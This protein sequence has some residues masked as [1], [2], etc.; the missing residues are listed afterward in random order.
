M[1]MFRTATLLLMMVCVAL[2]QYNRWQPEGEQIPGPHGNSA[3]PEWVTEMQGWTRE[4]PS[5]FDAWLA[6]IRA[7]RN[8]RLVRIG[9]HDSEYRRP[10]FQWAQRN[11]ISPQVM[12]EER[13]LF[14]PATSQYTV[15]R[16]LKDL[17]QRYGGIDSVLIWPVYPNLGI[18]DRNLLDF[19]RDLPGGLPALRKMVDDFHRHNV[20]VFFPMMPW[21]VGTRPEGVPLWESVAKLMAEVGADGVNGD[22]FAGVPRAF[23]DASDRTGHP[24][25]FEPENDLSGD[26]QLI[27]NLQ[28]W[29]YWNYSWEPKISKLKWLESRH[30][31]N[32]CN[33]WARDKNDDLQYA[34]FNGVGYVSWENIWGIWNGITP[35]DGEAL[36]R[37]SRIERQF[38]P[39][40]VSRDWLPHIPVLQFGSFASQFPS[41]NQTLWLFVNRNAYDLAGDQIRVPHHDGTRYFDVYHGVELQPK[42]ENG[43]AVL[44]FELESRGYG[45]ILAA[46]E[47]DTNLASFLAEM[48]QMTAHRLRDFSGV[49]KTL[50]Q[51]AVEIPSAK[52]SGKPPDG[53]IRIPAGKFDFRVSG[54]EIEGSND[55]GVDVQYPWENSPRRHHLH[56][57]AVPSLYIDKY[58]VTNAEFKR[59]LDASGYHPPD[60]HNFL[61][62]WNNGA[63][64][65]GWAKKP[66]T[67]VSIE[68]ARAYARWAGKRLPHEWEWQ[69][70]AQGTDGRT[71][72]WG[73]E[74]NP[75]ALPAPTHGRTMF[76][77]DDVDAHPKGASPFG[78]MD[79]TGNVWQ[80]T[81]EY[82]DEHTRAAILRGSG[83][84]HP[85]GSLWYFPTAYK[86]SEHGKLLLIGPGKD[87]S[88]SV[89]FRCVMDAE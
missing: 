49:W 2:G 29:G 26:E 71:Y 18:D 52:S 74:W 38:A 42:V 89:G 9:Y 12:V 72:P 20:K 14:D 1:K 55:E 82:V 64:P 51:H 21:D 37:V 5:D 16:Y 19:Y 8:E 60:P 79:L 77:P 6:D 40:L 83:S 63:Y 7:W 86:L 39:L 50:P 45:A 85:E 69:Y 44:A 67:W 47:S 32:V 36:R 65:E 4:R 48:K 43:S 25:V 27:W 78:V 54:V 22:T 30:M 34:F 3:Q 53:M 41:G 23:R 15:D 62:S 88:A 31:V 59:F 76:P 87:R 17:N 66:V 73:N 58:P 33:R 68:D 57:I 80:W 81:D 13:Y 10:E 84:Y 35:R 24:V 61:R 11:F 70:A 75:D 56:T 28:T 46:P